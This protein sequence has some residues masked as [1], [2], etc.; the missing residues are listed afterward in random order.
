MV[1]NA[2]WGQTTSNQPITFTNNE[3]TL[4]NQTVAVS[5]NYAMEL[6]SGEYTLHISGVC[7]I[8]SNNGN[9]AAV[10]LPED[11]HLTIEGSGILR[12]KGNAGVQTIMGDGNEKNPKFGKITVKGG[13]VYILG[14]VWH[15]N[16]H[17]S[18]EVQG[19]IAFIDGNVSDKKAQNT[20]GI[21]FGREES[22]QGEWNGTIYYE[23][24][25]NKTYEISSLVTRYFDGD[26]SEIDDKINLN[27]QGG[28][29]KLVEGGMIMGRRDQVNLS[30]GFLSAYVVNYDD[31][32]ISGCNEEL[33]VPLDGWLYGPNTTFD[34][35]EGRLTCNTNYKDNANGQHQFFGW[36]NDN[37]TTKEVLTN[38]EQTKTPTEQ[39]EA[40]SVDGTTTYEGELV[41]LKA[42]WAVQEYQLV[43]TNNVQ[44]QSKT[45][46]SRWHQ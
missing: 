30:N 26:G 23:E 29:L 22:G 21:V 24:E 8:T 11:A 46:L 36:V 43:V 40:K 25:S 32:R 10:Y 15:D 37:L 41:A 19:G 33:N 3:A 42:A 2:V 39:P 18:V 4:N 27:L 7:E 17:A 12:I 45:L 34:V 1:G 16:G 13:T 31:N 44:M 5:N 9:D 28:T 35:L 38:G 6:S 14:D 20:E